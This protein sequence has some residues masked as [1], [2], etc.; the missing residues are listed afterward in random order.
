MRRNE[1]AE[2]VI[3]HAFGWVLGSGYRVGGYHGDV[4]GAGF[5]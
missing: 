2:G 3:M 1:F 4:A 5:T